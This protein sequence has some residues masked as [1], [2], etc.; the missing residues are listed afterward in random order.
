VIAFNIVL[1]LVCLGSAWALGFYSKQ[2]AD[3]PRVSLQGILDIPRDE[4]QPQN[5]LL[6]GVDNA[7]GLDPDD[8]VLTGRDPHEN[9]S[10]AIM[11]LRIDPNQR[12]AALLSLPRDLYVPIAGNHGRDKIN[13]AMA[14]GNGR[15]DLLIQTIKSNFGI[16]INHYM[17]VN[18]AAF[19]SLVDAVDGV[20]I[21]FDQPARDPNTGLYVD[22]SG[23]QQLDGEQALAFARSR[24][25]EALVDGRWKPDP[26]SDL[27][28]VARQQYFIKQAAKKAIARGARNPIELGNLIGIAQQH[29][30][31]DDALSPAQIL[32]LADR[33]NTFEP[34]D[35]KLF[36]PEVTRV[37]QPSGADTLVLNE[38]AAR[39]IF[40]IFRGKNPFV[41]ANG[42]TAVEVRNG[43]G[44]VGQGQ[45]AADQFA[46][47]GFTIT[48]VTDDR[49]Q[50]LD[51]TVVRY[52]P[53]ANYIKAAVLVARYLD[54]TPVF[55]ED[56]AL[57]RTSSYVAVVIGR[58]FTAV[59]TEPRPIEDFADVLARAE[60]PGTTL[61]PTATT[62]PPATTAAAQSESFVPHP[63]PNVP[64]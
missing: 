50:R 10:D 44:R 40:D 14:Y 34:D 46:A 21:W 2:L 58:D 55:E 52:A 56:P 30:K 53:G 17:Q 3:I 59:R 61:A 25:Y 4:N 60:D 28:R 39:P 26:T 15:P 64:C 63:D 6:V 31:I 9:L 22:A 33:F 37:I 18:F 38:Q 54:G 45:T 16:E 41:D 19:R 20:N 47:Q 62:T 49:S 51:A 1:V 7:E 12:Q 24:K 32:D 35:L 5:F 48:G 57:A 13:V 23:C 27:G 8:P 11:I 29:M 43:T 42:A 36:T